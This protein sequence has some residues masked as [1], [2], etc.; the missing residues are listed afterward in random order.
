MISFKQ[1]IQ[2]SLSKQDREKR[3]S[4]WSEIDHHDRNLDGDEKNHVDNWVGGSHKQI[5]SGTAHG[6][7]I[8]HDLET[9]HEAVHARAE[10]IRDVIRKH[11]GD[12]ITV[13]RGE[14]P[15]QQQ[16]HGRKNVISSWT[17]D[18]NA[19]HFFASGQKRYMP[20]KVYSEKE[21]S[22]YENNLNKTGKSKVGSHLFVKNEHGTVDHY[23]NGDHISEI[24]H[25][26]D[27]FNANNDYAKERNKK[28][29][30]E[31][32]DASTRIK[33]ITVPVD[34]VVWATNRANQQEVILRNE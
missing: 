27:H 11:Y 17:T 29:S 10:P 23:K 24:D 19:A 4:M 14:N 15:D 31:Y 6:M 3:R 8:P 33:K 16:S 18:K 5:Q 20:M 9:H 22:T 7:M 13:Y 12:N 25:I 30:Q 1:F 2:E 32:K 28:R 26:R 34:K 21:I